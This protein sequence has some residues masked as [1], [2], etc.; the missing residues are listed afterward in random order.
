MVTV[1]LFQTPESNAEQMLERLRQRMPDID[2]KLRV[3]FSIQIVGY[4]Q[5]YE[6]A[7]QALRRRSGDLAASMGY[8]DISQNETMVGSNKNIHGS[9]GVIYARIHELGGMAGRHHRVRLRAR[10]YMIS[11]IQLYFGTGY[12][13]REAERFLQKQLDKVEQG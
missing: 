2:R 1:E 5:Q 8:R 7:G 13:E 10:R 9:Y 6:L 3:M 4:I 12:A 11:G